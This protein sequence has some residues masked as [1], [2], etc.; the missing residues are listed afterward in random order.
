[1]ALSMG[2]E[3]YR[4]GWSCR[5]SLEILGIGPD[6]TNQSNGALAI[7]VSKSAGAA[8]MSLCVASMDMSGKIPGYIQSWMDAATEPIQLRTYYNTPE[9]NVG[10]VKAYEWL[11]QNS[12]EDILVFAHD[13]VEVYERGWNERIRKVFENDDKVALCGFGGARHHGTSD[14]YKRPYRV[15]QLVRREYLSNVKD[16]ETHGKRFTG[17]IQ[18]GVLDGFVLCIRRRFLDLIAGF[19]FLMVHGVDFIGYDYVICALARR[20]EFTIKVIGVQC[21]HYGGG[22]SVKL[23]VDRQ[24]EYDRFHRWYYDEFRDVMPVTTKGDTWSPT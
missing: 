16:A 20:K 23:N 10:V 3:V 8:T 4:V 11:Y 12:T 13:D 19:R 15:N 6:S 7:P 2:E 22:T 21:H 14:L 24:S 17:E 5:V 18:V 9:D 1:M